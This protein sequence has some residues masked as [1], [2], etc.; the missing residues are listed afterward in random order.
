MTAKSISKN[1]WTFRLAVAPTTGACL[2]EIKKSEINSPTAN[3]S[4]ATNS[5][6]RGNL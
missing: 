4:E 6:D 5:I 2:Y 1:L 3:V